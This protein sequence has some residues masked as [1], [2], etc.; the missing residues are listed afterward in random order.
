MSAETENMDSKAC[1]IPLK[2]LTV[3]L[4]FHVRIL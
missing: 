4:L 3:K 1:K 2:F